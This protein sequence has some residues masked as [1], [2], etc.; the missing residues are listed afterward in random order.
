MGGYMQDYGTM[1][2]TIRALNSRHETMDGAQCPKAYCHGTLR[3][4]RG[5]LVCSGCV[6][7]RAD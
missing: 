2:Q 3:R 1:R 7:S 4:D 5:T 6:G